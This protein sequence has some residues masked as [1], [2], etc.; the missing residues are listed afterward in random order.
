V[1]RYRLVTE[2]AGRRHISS[3]VL[4]EAEAVVSLNLDAELHEQA[5][6]T[7]DR[8]DDG[9]VVAR[10][11]TATRLIWILETSPMDDVL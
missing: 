10:R 3:V 9:V 7:V 2:Q 8:D 4:N 5:G 6:W 1:T 11:G